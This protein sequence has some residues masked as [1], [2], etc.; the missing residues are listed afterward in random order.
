MATMTRT[1]GP[2]MNR[3]G[4]M[5]R[6]AALV[7]SLFTG[8]GIAEATACPKAR[9]EYRVWLKQGAEYVDV[10]NPHVEGTDLVYSQYG[11]EVR[12]SAENLIRIEP[13]TPE[14]AEMVRQA[15]LWNLRKLQATLQT[16][17]T[18]VSQAFQDRSRPGGHAQFNKTLAA[19]WTDLEAARAYLEACR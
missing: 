17:Q 12:Q 2:M 4:H 19:G 10:Q 3:I 11:G 8:V 16:N 6:Y 18:N 14:T 5:V 9:L 7:L 13:L 15:H 1:E